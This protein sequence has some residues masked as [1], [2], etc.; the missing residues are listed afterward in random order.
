MRTQIFTLAIVST[1]SLATASASII[2]DSMT[3]S[4]PKIGTWDSKAKPVSHTN[5]PNTTGGFVKIH[6]ASD[7]TEGTLDEDTLPNT[8]TA[9]LPYKAA[10]AY[11]TKQTTAAGSKF[12]ARSKVTATVTTVTAK[13]ITWTSLAADFGINVKGP[14]G[15]TGETATAQWSVFDPMMFDPLGHEYLMTISFT[16]DQG[17]GFKF[18]SS[19]GP[20][21]S[22]HAGAFGSA[23]TTL[24]GYGDLFSWDVSFS[25]PELLPVVNFASNPLLGLDDA[26]VRASILR[27]YSLSMLDRS[28]T[29]DSTGFSL[30]ATFDVPAGAAPFSISTSMGSELQASTA[31]EPATMCLVGAAL[32]LIGLYRR[33]GCPENR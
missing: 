12:E 19:F 32:A 14:T 13:Q 23:A 2:S 18:P 24:P 10:A 8:T 6:A 21:D 5:T 31:P 11:A 16:P 33:R 20:S 26:A 1:L 3:T 9:A 17:W 29:F 28:W 15:D 7:D 27:R 4:G 30:S 25:S 22:V